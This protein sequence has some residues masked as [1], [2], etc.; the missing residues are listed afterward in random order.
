MRIT[1]Q[2]EVPLQVLYRGE[3]IREEGFRL[4]LLVEDTSIDE[5]KP[6]EKVNNVHKK[7]LLTFLRL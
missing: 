5:L 3:K 7:Q 4:D 6:I 1:F 2:S